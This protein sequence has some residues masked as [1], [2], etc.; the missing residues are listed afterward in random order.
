MLLVSIR[1]GNKHYP[2]PYRWGRIAGYIVTGL[3]LYAVVALMPDLGVVLNYSIR[4]VLIFIYILTYLKIEKI[5]L[6]KLK[7]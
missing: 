1:L 6:W 4:T 3:A 5:S 7:F 2:I